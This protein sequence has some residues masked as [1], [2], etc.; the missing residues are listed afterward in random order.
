MKPKIIFALVLVASVLL[1]LS[2]C[3]MKEQ[4]IVYQ[5]KERPVS[6]VEEIISDQIEVENPELDLEVS[7]IEEQED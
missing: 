1:S 5:G 3:N 4:T 6:E 2:G 7:I